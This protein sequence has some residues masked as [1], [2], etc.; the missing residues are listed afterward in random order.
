ML[1]ALALL[2]LAA[3]NAQAQ[4][5]TPDGTVS[6]PGLPEIDGP[7]APVF[8]HV[9]S[10]DDVGGATVRAFRLDEPLNFDGRLDEAAYER[11]EPISGF[12]QQ[13]PLEGAP[14]TEGTD[15][16]V[17][18]DDDTIFVSARCW[19]SQPDRWVTGNLQRDGNLTQTENFAVVFDPFYNHRDGYYFQTNALGAMRDQLFTDEGNPNSS[20]NTVWEVRTARFSGGWTL[21]MAIPFKSLRYRSSGPQTW[22]VN[23]RRIVRW[24]N[25][26]SYLTRVAAQY[27]DPGLYRLSMGGTLVGL[28]TPSSRNLEA[29]GYALGTFGRET[30]G[31]GDLERF[32]RNAGFDVSY[33]LTRGL[34]A[35]ATY[36]TDFA[37][38]EE[39]TTQVNLTRFSLFFPEKREFFLESQ[40][41]FQF[42]GASGA[43]DVPIM[44]FSRRIGL[45]EGLT[46]PVIGGG[47]LTGRA[48][49]FD[50][51]LLQVATES[52]APGER[53]RTD[54]SVVRLKRGILRQSYLGLIGARRS[55]P[56]SGDDSNLTG[57]LDVNLAL[58]RTLTIASYYARTWSPDRSGNEASYRVLADYNSDRYG[59]KG[60]RLSVGDD[61]NPEI[62]YVRRHDLSRTAV[63]GRYSVR[64]RESTF[65]RRVSLEG[66]YDD[67]ADADGK[68]LQTRELRGTFRVEMHTGDQWS[69]GH[70]DTVDI[71]TEPF[72]LQSAV[73]APGRSHFRDTRAEYQLGQQH[74]FSG[75]MFLNVGSFY[76]GHRTQAGVSAGRIRISPRFEVEPSVTWSRITLP[77]AELSPWAATTRFSVTPTTTVLIT[78]IVQYNSQSRALGSSL[79]L[80]WEYSA[81]SDIFLVFS[82]GRTYSETGRE[83]AANYSLALKVT[84]LLRF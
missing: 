54:F 8:P 18:F 10:R 84:R 67:A 56:F 19:D 79:R 2:C 40:G 73:V 22:G 50:V 25:E 20:W 32:T 34:V 57:G 65:M 33:G 26:A 14:A 71:L 59:L 24:K 75:R 9:I 38:V 23:F 36:N 58:S 66:A 74:R 1:T 41:L 82:D 72:A 53:P 12:I 45:D 51:G 44:F 68:A 49:Q 70:V 37:Q 63:D 16:W 13:D 21:E 39:D 29:K 55:S 62:G 31:G 83:L 64:P 35:T 76:D 47:R 78:S 3:G 15:V 77:D 61:F 80:R 5:S 30:N 69:V 60:E 46:V 7:P 28:E 11:I 81:G 4:P 43:T 48:G 6:A 42:G 17:F 52:E 27:G